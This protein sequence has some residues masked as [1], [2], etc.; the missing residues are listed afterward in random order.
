MWKCFSFMTM[1][2]RFHRASSDFLMLW[3]SPHAHTHR[4]E[5]SQ[6]TGSSRCSSRFHHA[7]C[8]Y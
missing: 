3:S 7:C 4:E 2:F 6:C 5:Q 1:F 8:L